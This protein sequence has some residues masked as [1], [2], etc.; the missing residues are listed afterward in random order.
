MNLL[1]LALLSSAVLLG[2]AALHAQTKPIQHPTERVYLSFA[3][4]ADVNVGLDING[5]GQASLS[6]AGITQWSKNAPRALDVVPGE[7]NEI[8]LAAGQTSWEQTDVHISAPPGYKVYI[9]SPTSASIY[10]CTTSYVAAPIASVTDHHYAEFV[11]VPADGSQRLGPGQ[12][13][14]PTV[15]GE[16]IWSAGLGFDSAGREVGSLQIRLSA[17]DANTFTPAVLGFEPRS[18]DVA[19]TYDTNGAIEEIV[20]PQATV[21][22]AAI[23]GTMPGF[24]LT[25]ANGGPVILIQKDTAGG[26]DRLRIERQIGSRSTTWRITQTGI[27]LKDWTIEELGLNRVCTYTSTQLGNGDR[28]E[29]VTLKD[30][31]NV[32]AGKSRRIY[33][34]FASNSI[35]E[36]IQEIADPN[37]SALTT[38][39]DYYY[40]TGDVGTG[41]YGKLKSIT[42]PDGSWIKYTYYG[43]GSAGEYGRF[44]QLKSVMS[45]WQD[46]P[47]TASAAT[48]T[49][50][51]LTLFDYTAE[52]SVYQEDLSSTETKILNQ[53]V[54]L[55]TEASSFGS[56]ANGQPLRTETVNSYTSSGTYLTATRKVYHRTG[57]P[58]YAGRLYSQTSPDGSKVSAYYAFD[59]TY[60]TSTTLQGWNT[61]VDGSAVQVTTMDG[62][63]IDPIYLVPNRSTRRIEWLSVGA[64]TDVEVETQ[65]YTSSGTWEKIGN[66]KTWYEQ[67]YKIREFNYINNVET[68][69]NRADGIPTFDLANDGTL[70]SYSCDALGRVVW[71][72]KDA[73]AASGVYPAQDG[74]YTHFKYDAAGR[75]LWQRT[76]NSSDPNAAGITT[77]TTYDLAGRP[78]TS[79]DPDGLVTT[80]SYNTANRQST[81]TFP[82]GATRITESWRDGS[83]KSVTGTAVTAGYSALTVNG[84]GT[85]T[86]TSYALHAG[87][88]SNPTAAP[89]WSRATT[90]WAGRTVK[91]ENPAPNGSTFTK[92][93]FYD[94]VGRLSKTTEPGLAD[95]LVAY[96]AFGEAYRSGLDLS[97]SGA[98]EPNSTDRLSET[99][100]V[101]EKDGSGAW[102]AKTTAYG[103]NQ[104]GSATALTMGVTKQ[105]LT[106]FSASGQVYQQSETIATDIFGNT[107]TQNLVVDRGNRLVTAT[108]DVSDSTID[109]V[110]IA[111]NGLPQ[112]VQSAQSLISRTYYDSLGRVLKQTDPRTDPNPTPARIAYATNSLRV[113]SQQDT[114]GNTT[115]FGYD[116]STGRVISTTNPLNKTSYVSYNLR[117][118]VTRSWGQ[119][120]YPTENDYND[121][122]EQ[123][124]LSTFRGGTGW[125]ASTWPASPGPA[126]LSTFNFQPSTG[127]LL[128]KTDA[129]GRTVTYAY[130]ARGQL[131]TRT[132][133]RGVSTTYAYSTTTGEQTGI[134]YSDSTPD[135]TYTYNRLGQTATIADVTGTRTFAYST[136]NT[137][138]TSETLPGYFDARAITRSYDTTTTGGKGRNLGFT[139][140]GANA[141]GSD[142]SASYGYD[143]YG[144]FNQLS[145][146]SS[147]LSTSHTYGFAANTNLIGTIS[148]TSGWT[149]TMTYESNRNLLASINGTFGASS[150]AQFAYTHDVLGRRATVAESGEVFSR[151][152]GAGLSTLYGY[153]DRS[154]VTS[155]Q[156]YHGSNPANTSSPVAG[157]GFGYVFDN[158]GNRTSS[159]TVGAN[160]SDIR[161]T[162]YANN[163]LNQVAT[164]TA[165]ASSDVTGLAPTAATITINSSSSG[166]TR[167]GDYYYK[168]VTGTPSLWQ[169]LAVSS[170][171][172]GSA[173][174]YSYLAATPESFTYDLDGNVTDDGRWHYVWDAENQLVSMETSVAAQTI[175]VP[176]QFLTFKYDY[177]GRRVRKTV[178][179]WNGSTYVAAVD[180]K[181]IYNGWNLIAEHDVLASNAA[182][183]RYT[184]D[185]QGAGALLAIFDIPTSTTHLPAYDGNG[186]I[187]A[188]VN[189]ATGTLT[190]TY[191]YSSFGETL[192]ATGTYAATNNF[193]FSTQYT[194]AETGLL[195][196][197]YR[198]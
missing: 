159:S 61:A 191:E 11:I 93:V 102:W 114:A 110:S 58:D 160:L 54:S 101:L 33:R 19:V 67:G 193:R 99:A 71:Q 36:L 26:I 5:V 167:Q 25:Y 124:T 81:I 130:N 190:A 34:L 104:P 105:R 117:G 56:S 177:L 7:R 169:S 164:R 38:T 48:T 128:S 140:T 100:T 151:Y 136:A 18:T 154:E 15:D 118:Q 30:A 57:D 4:K 186:N 192:R 115:I 45:P 157:R 72:R 24:S 85:I 139:L 173:T 145:A 147:S 197:G 50:C 49:N 13:T 175:G 40:D 174:R 29:D 55:G 53:T 150:K 184:W 41:S 98:L 149:E 90:D 2:G 89:R 20:A 116:G 69:W 194:D 65:I 179:N 43:D 182:V 120:T 52:R 35:D 119:T 1:R 126:D 44:G 27:A 107:T 97:A 42:R 23:T 92:L 146:L 75:V 47:T 168:N 28:Q 12:V 94:S 135:L 70:T 166:I 66:G 132:W 155:A 46:S 60:T 17:I 144:R 78:A 129:A 32:V 183:A 59:S 6:N 106:G 138:L 121:Y 123:T 134:D 8:H 122:G 137:T 83:A 188:L 143:A 84:D 187:H 163:N 156:S 21:T 133:A 80:Y 195:Y 103:Y 91:Q 171:L 165:P 189:R 14:A 162:T 158:I 82:G 22:V 127:V 86:G 3:V 63:T 73:V 51:K 142:Y 131:A 62:K 181:F 76:N 79:T 39:Y 77:S 16:F 37:G 180:R 9:K 74:I 111:R 96:N 125:D 141:T 152:V 178:A 185:G 153:N 87:D 113:T 10:R 170:S 148:E 198:Y 161:T 31:A 88:L 95:A 176:R 64:T 68:R 196:Y 108:T 109:V 172:G 112:S